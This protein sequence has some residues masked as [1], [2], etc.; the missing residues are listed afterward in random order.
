MAQDLENLNGKSA[1]DS[2]GL[3]TL[4]V[5]THLVGRLAAGTTVAHPIDTSAHYEG[6]LMIVNGIAQAHI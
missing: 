3:N 1:R 5:N 6:V 2:T 4:S